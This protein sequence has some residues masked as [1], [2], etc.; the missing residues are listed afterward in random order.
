MPLQ[1]ICSN[2]DCYYRLELQDIKNGTS[3]ATPQNCPNCKSPTISICPSCLFPLLGN[4]DIKNP[5]CAVCR[6]DIRAAFWQLRA[7][8]RVEKRKSETLQVHSPGNQRLMVHKQPPLYY[9]PAKAFCAPDDG[10]EP[11]TAR[12][13]EVVRHLADG[14]SN[15]E[16]STAL[17]ITVRTAETYRARIMLKLH[18]H[19]F[20]DLMRYAVRHNLVRL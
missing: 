8:D 6:Q 9:R 2:A 10:T 12:E 18:A 5:R 17:A 14:K 20:S 7:R 11:L 15:K 16:V 1:A 4:I 3:N 19:S 13:I